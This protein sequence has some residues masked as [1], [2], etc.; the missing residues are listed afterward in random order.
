MGSAKRQSVAAVLGISVIIGWCSLGVASDRGVNPHLTRPP[1]IPTERL[2]RPP[3]EQDRP[4][5]RQSE[6]VALAKAAVKKELGRPFDEY[7]LKAAVFDPAA[8]SWSVTF[9]PK[10]PR[11]PSEG[12][13][14]VFVRADTRGTEVRRCS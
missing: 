3:P 10:E 13:V 2:D 7:E 1:D 5:L 11:V 8:N 4:I 9:Y 14:V 6:A 12:C